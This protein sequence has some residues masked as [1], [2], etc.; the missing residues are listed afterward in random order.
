MEYKYNI[1][2]SFANE[3]REYVEKVAAILKEN[4]VSVFYDKYEEVDLW[5]KDLGI[6]FEYI[7][8]RASKYVILFISRNYAQKK[9]TNYEFRNALSRA[10]E[11]RDEYILPAKLDDTK[12]EGLRD[13]I[14]FLDIKRMSPEQLASKI[15]E[16]LKREINIPLPQKEQANSD[17]DVYL[18]SRIMLS[19]YNYSSGIVGVTV[20]N[21][22]KEHRYFDSPIFEISEPLFHTN[23]FVLLNPMEN[24][25]FPKKMEYGESYRINY[26]LKKDVLE[27]LKKLRGKEVFLKA[28]VR[29]SIG[30][31]FVSNEM[32]IDN[33]F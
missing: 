4:E 28:I 3:D 23:T 14:G 6:H 25:S 32:N 17:V 11:S 18:S 24:I 19:N 20:T 7:Y 22:I 31:K 16:K 5:G 2:L 10:I 33:L 15:I 30:E 26:P 21:K 8:Q 27:E 1:A 12:L 29:T 9:W 13:S